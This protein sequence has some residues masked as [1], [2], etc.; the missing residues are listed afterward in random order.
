MTTPKLCSASWT[1]G[2]CD[3]HASIG[4]HCSGHYQQQHRNKPFRP[5]RQPHGALGVQL[6]PVTINL[7]GNDVE[8]LQLEALA[9]QVPTADVY[10]EAVAEHAD[11]IRTKPVDS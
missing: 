7:P 4:A 3:R 11:R 6:V 1:G 9:R 10:R 2:S 8:T 5:L